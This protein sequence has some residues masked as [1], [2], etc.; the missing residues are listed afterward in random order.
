MIVVS[1][2][3]NHHPFIN[4]CRCMAASMDHCLASGVMGA[5]KPCRPPGCHLP[6]VKI[7]WYVAHAMRRV[8]RMVSMVSGY[9]LLWMMVD[10]DVLSH[11]DAIRP[12]DKRPESPQVSPSFSVPLNHLCSRHPWLVYHRF[13]TT[14]HS[15]KT[16]AIWVTQ[17]TK[18]QSSGTG[19]F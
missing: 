18:T 12:G 14:N 6:A 13:M 9:L 17:P 8:M 3:H 15:F 19:P 16:P 1:I 2:I 10:S 5:S 11:W 7:G 4:H